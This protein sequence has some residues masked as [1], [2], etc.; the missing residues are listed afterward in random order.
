M[1]QIQTELPEHGEAVDPRAD[2]QRFLALDP[3]FG[4]LARDGVA[5]LQLAH[6]KAVELHEDFLAG[7][8]EMKERFWQGFP[9]VDLTDDQKHV[10]WLHARYGFTYQEIEAQL[11]IPSSTI[12]DWISQARKKLA[13]Y[14]NN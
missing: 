13:A 7:Q 12:G 8:A 3:M 11:G 10:L 6:Q 14:L 5:R 9:N 1:R 4:H 2:A